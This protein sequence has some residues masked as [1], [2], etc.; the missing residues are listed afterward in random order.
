MNRWLVIEA[1]ADKDLKRGE[2]VRM[3]VLNIHSSVTGAYWYWGRKG[4]EHRLFLI[5]LRKMQTHNWDVAWLL[6]CYEQLSRIE[7]GRRINA[8]VQ[9]VL[10]TAGF[11]TPSCAITDGGHELMAQFT[12]PPAQQI[13]IGH[14]EKTNKLMGK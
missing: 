6:M 13:T 7:S 10:I 14:I 11:I 8:D 3:Q 12:N 5:D 9:A 4:H 1:F 2:N